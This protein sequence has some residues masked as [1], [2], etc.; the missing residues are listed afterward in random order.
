[1]NDL[2]RP[3]DVPRL[4]ELMAELAKGHRV[5][6]IWAVRRADGTSLP[7]ELSH[8]FTPDGLWQA[9]GRDITVR[10]RAEAVREQQRQDEHEISALVQRSL[11]PVLTEL[12]RRD[13]AV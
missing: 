12:G 3:D 13:L 7:L 2:V 8:A 1:M 10:Q 4:H 9:N 5:T 11:L 6:D